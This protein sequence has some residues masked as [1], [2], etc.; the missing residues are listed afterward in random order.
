MYSH[1]GPFAANRDRPVAFEIRPRASIAATVAIGVLVVR[2]LEVCV[3]TRQESSRPRSLRARLLGQPT[4]VDD[5][6]HEVAQRAGLAVVAIDLDEAGA[7]V[8]LEVRRDDV[9]YES[10]G[11]PDRSMA[12][13]DGPPIAIDFRTARRTRAHITRFSRS[14]ALVGLR[15]APE[16]S[17]ITLV[18]D[19][20]ERPL[21]S[22]MN[23]LQDRCGGEAALHLWPAAPQAADSA[24][25]LV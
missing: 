5:L 12:A 16:D 2:G 1:M 8:T 11:E 15:S 7:A 23:T 3:G 13:I 10:R 17:D 21:R 14:V 24:T 19:G 18:R 20:L 9:S 6:C 22:A 4:V 25:L